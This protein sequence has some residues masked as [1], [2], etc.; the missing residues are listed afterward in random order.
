LG[1]F[2]HFYGFKIALKFNTRRSAEE[3]G[4]FAERAIDVID[5]QF[6]A[7]DDHLSSLDKSSMLYKTDSFFIKHEKML[8]GAEKKWIRD[9]V[10]NLSMLQSI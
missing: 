3:I 10:K 7:M 4:K 9:A 6:K 2:P 8:F 5:Q 1:L